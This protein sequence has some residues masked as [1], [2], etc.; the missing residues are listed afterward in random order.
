[1]R[2]HYCQHHEWENPAIFDLVDWPRFHGASL[3]TT[4][5]KRLFVTKLINSLLPFQQ[6]QHLYK[7]S[8]SLGTLPVRL[9]VRQRRL[10]TL[11]SLL[12]SATHPSMGYIPAYSLVSD[13]AMEVGSI[14]PPNFPTLDGP[15]DLLHADPA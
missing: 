13:G 14:T 8:P 12:T 3:S 11:S 5:L 10:E 4:F 7:Q 2:A 1:M 9:R 6:Q 15:I